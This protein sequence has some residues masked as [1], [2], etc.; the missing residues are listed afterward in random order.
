M[1]QLFGIHLCSSWIRFW[2]IY[3]RKRIY[4]RCINVHY[5]ILKVAVCEFSIEFLHHNAYVWILQ[6]HMHIFYCYGCNQVFSDLKSIMFDVF[7]SKMKW[8]AL[9]SPSAPYST[10]FFS[11]IKVCI[12]NYLTVCIWVECVE[13]KETSY[14]YA[15]IAGCKWMMS[16]KIF[17]F[18]GFFFFSQAHL[19]DQFHSNS[20]RDNRTYKPDCSCLSLIEFFCG[21]N[22]NLMCANATT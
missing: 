17:T 4:C 16:K 15:R 12:L 5:F 14:T 2:T 3:H 11:T 20:N 22:F 8:I 13:N 10:P 21:V 18:D 6:H 7:K 1:Y 19:F 9:L